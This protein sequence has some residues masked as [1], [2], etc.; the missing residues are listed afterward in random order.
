MVRFG[1]MVAVLTICS[2]GTA[3]ACWPPGSPAGAAGYYAFTPLECVQ[4]PA[5]APKGS[6]PMPM[7]QTRDQW[8][9]NTDRALDAAGRALLFRNAQGT[10][11]VRTTLS[12]PPVVRVYS[13]PPAV[14]TRSTTTYSYS[15]RSA[16]Q[17]EPLEF[18]FR[19]PG[20]RPLANGVR[21][22]AAAYGEKD[23]RNPAPL[24]R[25]ANTLGTLGSCRR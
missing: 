24:R 17:F 3:Q 11:G 1:L 21:T 23:Y 5:V 8:Q 25:M 22:F 7:A 19:A 12:P 15:T 16:V 14:T 20:V 2:I 18:R 6:V 4:P 9:E 10:A 13:A